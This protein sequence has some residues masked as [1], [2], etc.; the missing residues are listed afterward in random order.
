MVKGLGCGVWGF[1][2]ISHDYGLWVWGLGFGV[3]GLGFG[4]CGLGFGDWK[5][6]FEVSD[7]PAAPFVCVGSGGSRVALGTSATKIRPCVVSRE[8][9]LRKHIGF[10]SMTFGPTSRVRNG[11]LE[12]LLL[13]RKF[14]SRSS[15]ARRQ[16]ST[17]FVWETA[18][19]YTDSKCT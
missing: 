18:V 8:S 15:L 16:F 7:D 19:Y 1:W 10:F 11:F 14:A 9:V 3:W 13:G 12:S 4:I 6:G 5:L 2:F 17:P